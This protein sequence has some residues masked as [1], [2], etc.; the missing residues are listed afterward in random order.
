MDVTKPAWRGAKALFE[1]AI[2]TGGA[3]TP[4]TLK[5]YSGAKNDHD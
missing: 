4:A 2:E 3:E 5:F 1:A